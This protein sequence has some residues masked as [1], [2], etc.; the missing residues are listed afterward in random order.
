MRDFYRKIEEL[1]PDQIEE[2]ESWMKNDSDWQ[3]LSTDESLVDI[4]R[5]DLKTLRELD[6]TPKQIADR[7]ESLTGQFHWYC[8]RN[9]LELGKEIQNLEKRGALV[10]GRY[11]VTVTEETDE[12]P[13]FFEIVDRPF[14]HKRTKRIIEDQGLDDASAELLTRDQYL[15]YVKHYGNS[16]YSITDDKQRK[17]IFSHPEIKFP[18]VLIHLI[19]NHHFFGGPKAPWNLD[20]EKTVNFLNLEPGK[21]YTPKKTRITL[22]QERGYN[23][24]FSNDYLGSSHIMNYGQKKRLGNGMI[25]YIWDNQGVILSEKNIK[26]KEPP[27]IDSIL[28]DLHKNEVK[29]GQTI[30]HLNKNLEFVYG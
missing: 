18:D 21:D 23:S 7:L 2:I 11:F 24:S 30:I 14:S 9:K 20:A 1:N 26:F 4:V 10:E 17:E 28:I 19:R 8:Y 5:E 27:E 15:N 12:Q 25:A 16:V 22:W 13:C 3:F 29:P 6:V